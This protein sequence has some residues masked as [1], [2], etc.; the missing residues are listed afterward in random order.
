MSTFRF[1]LTAT[2]VAAGM[3][4]AHHAAAQT[5]E[6]VG[7]L[8]AIT[9]TAGGYEQSVK[10]APA[11]ISVITAAEI[12]KK[13]YT[14]VTDVLKN[15]PG[16][17]IQ[18]GGVE[19]S[20]MIRGMSSDYTL[21]LVDGRPQQDNQAFGLNGTST[22]AP[23]A[24]LPPL[25]SIERIE[26]IRGPSSSL[27]GSD[28]IGGVVNIITRKVVN[29]FSGSVTSEYIHPGAGNDV[30]NAGWTSSVALNM[31]IK[32]DVL[33]LQLTGGFRHQKEADF[34]GGDDNTAADPKFRNQNLG[35]K[36]G[37]RLDA[38]NTFT[39][40]GGRTTQQRWHNPGKSLAVDDA[41]SYS[42]AV[43]DNLFVTHEGRYKDM[44][45]ETYLNYD[46][47]E[48]PT[49]VNATTGNGIDFDTL[50]ANT[51]ATFFLGRHTV[52][53]GANYKHE[54]LQDGSTNGL[55]LPGIVV[56]TDVVTM[57]RKQKAVFLEDNW[58]LTDDLALLLSGRYDHS[59]TYGGK[60]S[61]K[62]YSVYNL[63]PQLAL[64]GGLTTGYKTPALRSAATDFGSTS[65]GGV[66]IG[67]PD[68]KPETTRNFE[69]GLNYGSKQTGLSGSLTVY[70][71][72]FKDKLLRTGRIC[73]QNVVCEWGGVTYPA[74]P[75]GYTTMTNVDSAELQ[76]VEWTLDWKINRELTYRHSYTY[77]ESEQT[78]GTNAG[79]PLNDI[80]EHMFN[81]A[82]DWRAAAQWNLWTQLNYRGKTSGRTTNASGSA[83]NDVRYPAYTFLDLGAVYDV[84][85]D[86]KLRFGVYNLTNK[87]VTPED[88]FAYVLD[89]RRYSVALNVRF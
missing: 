77:A 40:G 27:Y 89:G 74:H 79:K 4:L 9:V 41:A 87:T 43:R 80:P 21:F 51:Q 71:S 57:E 82:L 65:M 67:N 30:T 55:N 2:A 88:G 18:G 14:D 78:S 11:S 7:Q 60:F 19:Q 15:I 85:K 42:K 56:P 32:K 5:A 25:D 13:S 20:V 86:V 68:L 62:V 34:V 50:S 39:L 35:A 63:T 22:G 76:G 28:A 72:K 53:A 66:I 73:A 36:L 6:S 52:T 8:D 44:L 54:E 33:S 45:W 12:A 1:P 10:D 24:F 47:S 81:V 59:D 23:I 49:R 31:P 17:H 61:P 38:Q 70:K 58:Q 83:T 46:T 75:F 48:N 69:I 3:L 16:V 84:T 29:E 37:L 26:V 64:K